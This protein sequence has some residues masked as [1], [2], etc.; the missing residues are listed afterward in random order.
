M[1]GRTNKLPYNPVIWPA[2]PRDE[3]GD[4]NVGY[5]TVETTQ[6]YVW[7]TRG[8]TWDGKVYKYGRAKD[9]LYAGYGA[10]NGSLIDVSD[11]INSTTPVAYVAGQ[12][13]VTVTIA[14]TEGYASDGVIAEDE[15]IGSQFVVGHG[16]AALTEQ[17][18]VMGNTAVASG[19]GTTTIEL[20]YPLALAH[21][22]GVA[23][24]VP[25]NA[26]GYL[27]NTSSAI[28]SVVGVPNIT[29]ATGYNLWIQTWG[30]CW[31]VPGGADTTPGDAAANRTVVFVGDGSVNG[32]NV[33][34]LEDGYQV[35]GFIMDATESGTGTMPLVMLQ[36][37]I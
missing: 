2:I 14:A 10:K 17:R 11:L 3:T 23:C 4:N 25:F 31:C 24:E 13:E 12:R 6:R 1:I 5:G 22:S 34:T 21:A 16:A 36:I 30:P 33:I 37:S 20:D 29:A 7:G 9:T 32:V 35:A 27:I 15:L 26:Y 28:A 18:T 8:L 19:G